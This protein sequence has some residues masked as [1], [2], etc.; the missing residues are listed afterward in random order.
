[1]DYLSAYKYWLEHAPVSYRD[2][3]QS[4]EGNSLALR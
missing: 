2:M 4:M 1:M 3:L